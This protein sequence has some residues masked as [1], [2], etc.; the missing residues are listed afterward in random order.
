MKPLDDL[1]GPWRGLS[2]QDGR[3]IPEAIQLA[4][5]GGTMSGS[6][7]DADGNFTLD[8]TYESNIVHLVRIYTWTTEPSQSGAGIVYDYFGEWNGSFI[9]GA[10]RPREAPY[11]GGPFEMWPES[12]EISL[13]ESFSEDLALA[14]S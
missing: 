2:T 14:P 12:E 10:W 9:E 4:I 11:Y 13:E 1:S 7:T 8:G 3:R 5:G 6:G